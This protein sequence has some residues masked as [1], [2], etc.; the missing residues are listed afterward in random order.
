VCERTTQQ[1]YAWKHL[2]CLIFT[3]Y[4]PQ[5]SPIISGESA[6]SD[7]RLLNM[8]DNLFLD[9]LIF[10]PRLQ[11]QEDSSTFSFQQTHYQWSIKNSTLQASSLISDKTIRATS[12][13]LQVEVAV[14]FTWQ[15]LGYF[16]WLL[17]ALTSMQLEA[18]WQGTS[19]TIIGRHLFGFTLYKQLL[20]Y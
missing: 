19:K 9:H 18:T 3:D 1:E 2:G 11:I 10:T 8:L 5:T 16:T 20:R 4:F 6:E 17:C 13:N 12:I 15:L 7:L 14:H